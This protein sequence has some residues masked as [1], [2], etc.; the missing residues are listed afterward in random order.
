MVCIWGLA[1]LT[2][3]LPIGSPACLAQST[4]VLDI[5]AGALDD[6]LIS[7]ARQTGASI[8]LPGKMPRR[9]VKAVAGPVS[10]KQALDLLLRGTGYRAIPVGLNAW[11]LMP[12]TAAPAPHP[13]P[14]PTPQS[15]AKPAPAPLSP[16]EA[17]GPPPQDIIVTAAKRTGTLES[18]PIDYSVVENVALGRFSNLPGTASL[19]SLNVG[20]TLSNLGP[21]RNRAFLRGISDSPFNGQTQSTVA[22]L[23]DDA[24]V[25]FNAPDPDLRL[26]D[27][28]RVE[29][30]KGPQGPLYGT[31]AI[32]GVFRIVT[33][34]P[35]LDQFGMSAS[36]S[37]EALT[38]GGKGVGGT[39]MINVP[40]V[41]DKLGIRA[42]AYGALEPGW[43]D[44]ARPKGDNSNKAQRRGGRIALRWRP[45]P[46]WTIDLAGTVQ[47]LH[48]DDSQY[49]VGPQPFHRSGILPEPHDNDFANARMSVTGAVGSVTLFSTTSWTTHE[50]DSVLDASPAAGLFGAA[51]PLLF[52][53]DRLYR[54]INHEMRASG[55]SEHGRWMVGG[56]ILSATTHVDAKIISATGATTTM[57]TLNQEAQEFALFG[58]L[59]FDLSDILAIDAGAR[60]FSTSINDERQ[61]SGTA[62]AL[63][64]TQ[65]GVSPSIAISLKPSGRSYYYIRMATAFRPAGLSPFT[66][67]TDREF[68][69]DRMR[70]IELG[71]R[72]H[73]E[74]HSI[75]GQAVLFGSRWIDIQSD[76]LLPNGL[77][78]TRNSGRGLIYGLE[79]S[80]TWRPADEWALSGGIALQHARLEKPAAGLSLSA[81]QSL[82]LV[83]G[84]RVNFDV[85]RA[86]SL[87]AWEANLTTHGAFIGPAR[88]SLDPGLDRPFGH[89]FTLDLAA[90]ARRGP[91]T[92]GLTLL[93]LFDSHADTH[94]Y[95]NPFSIRNTDQH[96][97]LRPSS[98]SFSI[99]WMLP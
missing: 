56:S 71:G 43:I 19:A 80:G 45:D 23:L 93:N 65:R 79:A 33:T 5:R 96:V 26:V 17:L 95:G 81:D 98:L 57:G 1:P 35:H 52:E 6:A 59:G 38:N 99:G 61:E 76:Y 41:Q 25:T 20:L 90:S 87:G 7:L 88:L 21:G 13:K 22:T 4:A 68:D 64:S 97:P 75:T 11:R 34:K 67:T 73:S 92:F 48:V 84:Y 72:W 3:L 49:G 27:I 16:R 37:G 77:V 94:P 40:I 30:L 9:R 50:V 10:T 12:D 54:V 15:P 91:W 8:G 32:G 63:H 14:A 69:S 55:Q 39:A 89:T 62:S 36:V 58:D 28:D 83:P 85:T 24:R 70:T 66:P 60:L 2:N 86:F 82:P 78:A 74:T 18:T 31:G 51:A 46:D 42:V 44:N 53:D 29:L 47:L